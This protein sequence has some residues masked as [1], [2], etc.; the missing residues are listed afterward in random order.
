MKTNAQNE[1]PAA[2]A[3][4]HTPEP[5]T[6]HFTGEELHALGY[7]LRCARTFHGPNNLEKLIPAFREED[8]HR[9]DLLRRINS[10]LSKLD[11]KDAL[12]GMNPDKLVDYIEKSH[13]LLA[14]VEAGCNSE[15]PA[16]RLL[17]GETRAALAAL[18][19]GAK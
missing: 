16:V 5:M 19:G 8:A 6:I 3:S 14:Y 15:G 10:C 1:T 4:R 13:T 7:S 12:A 11:G 2:S 17:V 18:R 9:D